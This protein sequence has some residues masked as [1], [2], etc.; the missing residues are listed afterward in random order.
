MEIRTANKKD[1]LKLDELLSKLI[2]YEGLKYDPN[3]NPYIKIEQFFERRI[4]IGENYILVA[5]DNGEMIGFLSADSNMNGI[6]LN[7]E[8]K[9]QFL[10]IEEKY[11]NQGVGTKLMDS[12][13]KYAKEQGVKYVAVNHYLAN[14]EGEKLYKKFGFE[15]LTIDRRVEL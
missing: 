1:A 14:E 12:Y 6:K 5:E 13:L 2:D 10:Y 7:K 8:T 11:R 4:G 15:V 9:I 3:T